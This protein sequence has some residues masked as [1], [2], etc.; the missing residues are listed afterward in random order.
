MFLAQRPLAFHW[1]ILRESGGEET[2]GIEGQPG[3]RNGGEGQREKILN[4][5]MGDKM[6][7]NEG[8]A[9]VQH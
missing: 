6:F 3:A 2:G 4:G 5:L 1:R 8:G 9:A 7:E